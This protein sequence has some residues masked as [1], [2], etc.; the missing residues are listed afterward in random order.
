LQTTLMTSVIA[1]LIVAFISAGLM[2]GAYLHAR[3][4]NQR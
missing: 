3:Y 1:I 2:L 4:R